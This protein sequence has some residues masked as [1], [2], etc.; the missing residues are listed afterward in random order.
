MAL[1]TIGILHAAE[2]L[3]EDLVQRVN[4]CVLSVSIDI[5]SFVV[6]GR[7]RD[8]LLTG[9]IH[10]SILFHGVELLVL[11]LGPCWVTWLLHKLYHLRR[12]TPLVDLVRSANP[13]S[14]ILILLNIEDR[15]HL[16]M[17][18][19]LLVWEHSSH[20]FL[21][22][23]ARRVTTLDRPM[24]IKVVLKVLLTRLLHD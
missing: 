7:S 17:L 3:E 9:K 2:V 10:L 21:K 1:Y 12:N 5:E 23:E 20:F 19:G 24:R 11:S 16:C 22:V 18:V 15:W 6:R 8:I 14:T 13:L 4:L